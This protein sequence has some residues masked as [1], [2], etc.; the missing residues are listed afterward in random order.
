MPT[1]YVSNLLQLE[2]GLHIATRL[3]AFLLAAIREAARP[4]GSMSSAAECES[5]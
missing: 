2:G 3:D 5:D 4:R 1:S